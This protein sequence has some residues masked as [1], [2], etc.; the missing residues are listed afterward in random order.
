MRKTPLLFASFLCLGLLVAPVRAEAPPEGDKISQGLWW[1]YQLQYEQAH[2]LFEDYTKEN[3]KD[4]S[5][6]FYKTATDWWQLA[7][8]FDYPLPEIQA[9]LEADYQETIKVAKALMSSAEDSK[10]KAQACLYWGG[11]EGLKG[12]WLV[13]QKQYVDA[14][15]LGKRGNKLLKKALRYDPELYDAYMGLGIYDYFTDTLSGVVRMLASLL[16][17]GDRERGLQELQLAIEKGTHARVEAMIFLIEIYTF[18]ENQPDQALPM[19]IELYK[20][21]PQSPAMHLAYIMAL[22][23]MKNWKEMTPEAQKYLDRSEKETP[24]YSKKGIRPA[25][26]CL[27]MSALL[28]DRKPEKSMK[29]LQRIFDGGEDASRWV[30]FAYLRRGQIHDLRKERNL[31]LADYKI[32][33]NRPDFWG[34]RDEAKRSL[35]QPFSLPQ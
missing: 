6:Y 22:Y 19:T 16:I 31:A 20:Q 7:Q 3:P 30:T 24:Y 4:P 32:V 33:L 34:S 26:Y 13:T 27:A 2:Q 11:A 10:T 23:S 12:R 17:H 5:G 25:L 35:T 28:G 9:R 21:F 1:L 29:Y 14:Y 18:E 8:E 15:F